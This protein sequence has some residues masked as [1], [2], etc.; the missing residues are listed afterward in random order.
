MGR[1]ALIVSSVLLLSSVCASSAKAQAVV[2]APCLET[3]DGPGGADLVPWTFDPL[4]AEGVGWNVDATPAFLGDGAGGTA[5]P[6]TR[7]LGGVPSSASLNFN[8]GTNFEDTTD[9][10][11]KGVASSPVIDVTF[12]AGLWCNISYDLAFEIEPGLAS[13]NPSMSIELVN[14]T[15][16][17]TPTSMGSLT[18]GKIGSGMDYELQ[19][20]RWMRVN[21]W[22]F[23]SG[24]VTAIQVRFI[25]T[26][27]DDLNNNY[28]GMFVDNLRI[29]CEEYVLPSTPSNVSPADG[30][31]VSSPV[32]LDWSDATDSGDCGPGDVI[33]YTVQIDDD[34]AFGSVNYSYTPIVSNVLATVAAGTWYWRVAA[35]DGQGNVGA[36]S[37]ST[38]FYIEPPF[39]PSPP[40]GLYVNEDYN[41][42][43]TGRSGFVAPV[44]DTT[45]VFSAVYEDANTVDNAI[46]LEFQISDDPLFMILTDSGILTLSAPLPKGQRCPDFTTGVGLSKDTLYYWRCR[47]ADGGGFGSWSLAQS[48]RIGDAYDFGER[49]GSKNHSRKCWVATSAYGSENASPVV[50]LQAWRHE[51][52]EGFSAGRLFSRAYHVTGRAVAPSVA[53]SGV[54]RLA[55]GSVASVAGIP[56]AALSIVVLASLAAL[57]M[58]RFSGR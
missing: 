30:A 50:T 38:S 26:S 34:S 41:G 24:A 6:S 10:A 31:T 5:D 46:Q 44:I 57:G 17:A 13:S 7:S 3:F 58:G 48:F 27:V 9:G 23:N 40:S 33:S 52:L 20:G 45:P 37:A 51:E 39:L 47:F 14:Y 19:Q 12:S 35:V 15:V 42:A 36:W 56:A 53:G 29:T 16:P 8:D 43:Q 54:V 21:S 4:S 28:A 22:F 49:P 55:V 11:V 2:T 25:F 1:F 18:F 32:A